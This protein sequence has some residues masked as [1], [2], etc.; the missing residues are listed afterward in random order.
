MVRVEEIEDEAFVTTNEKDF[1]DDD[2]FTDTGMNLLYILPIAPPL[3]SIPISFT[4]PSQ[5]QL[6]PTQQTPKSP[7]SPKTTPPHPPC[8]NP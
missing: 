8:Q 4:T 2:D 1:E 6:T 3:Y 5:S 7:P